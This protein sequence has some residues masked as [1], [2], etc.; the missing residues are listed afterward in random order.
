MGVLGK[1]KTLTPPSG[2]IHQLW[3]S[4]IEPDGAASVL[5][6]ELD[7]SKPGEPLWFSQATH[8]GGWGAPRLVTSK[9]ASQALESV[10]GR[11]QIVYQRFTE[12]AEANAVGASSVVY[13]LQPPSVTS[14]LIGLLPG[15]ISEDDTSIVSDGRGDDLIVSS[16]WGMGAVQIVYRHAGGRFGPAQ[17]IAHFNAVDS[18]PL[19][20][21]MNERGEALAAWMC[22]DSG[23]ENPRG[24]VGVAWFSRGGEPRY[25][26][27]RLNA[28]TEPQ[29]A[30]GARGR[31]LVV[32]EAADEKGLVTLSGDRGHLNART[33]LASRPFRSSSPLGVAVTR[34]DT[35]LV[36]LSE[37]SRGERE[38]IGVYYAHL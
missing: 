11:P 31:W 3:G 14:S 37:P 26:T 16:E 33:K 34:D 20:A 22:H 4:E 18:C 17:T 1:V 15:E 38:R 2:P 23:S 21:T 32:F 25:L 27:A 36:A 8:A 6:K 12:G 35:A 7:G 10:N 19:T 28:Y 5:W 13:A 30:L 29:I 24:S 9:S